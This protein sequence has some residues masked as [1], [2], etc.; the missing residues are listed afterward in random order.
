ML[1]L[2]LFNDIRKPLNCRASLV[3]NCSHGLAIRPALFNSRDSVFM[4]LEIPAIRESSVCRLIIA[5]I[6]SL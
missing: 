2:L 1:M 3:I 4:N 5:D 6:S